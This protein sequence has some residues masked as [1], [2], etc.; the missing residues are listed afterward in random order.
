MSQPALPANSYLDELR[1]RTD[2]LELMP[3]APREVL[4]VFSDFCVSYPAFLD[5]GLALLRR[6]A[7]A[8]R[9]TLSDA[10][11][12]RVSRGVGRCAGPVQQVLEAGTE[13]EVVEVDDPGFAGPSADSDDGRA[14]PVSIQRVAARGPPPERLP[15]PS[16][17]SR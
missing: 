9:E 7:P 4:T 5:C 12:F 10:A 13:Q 1:A 3:E 14:A 11:W 8:L 17:L 15:P 16:I 6:P 2:A